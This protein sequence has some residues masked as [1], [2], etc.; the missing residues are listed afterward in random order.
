MYVEVREGRPGSTTLELLSKAR[1]LGT[2]DA[3]AL[4]PGAR[5]AAAALGSHGASRVLV[6]EDEAFAEYLAEPASDCL[7]GLVESGS[8]DL[9]LFSFTSDSRDVAGRLAARLGVGLISNAMDV[10]ASEAGF[11]ARVPYFGGAKVAT[12]R[13]GA[14]PAIVLVRPKS[15]EA[16]TTGGEA[17]VVEI[18]ARIRESSRRARIV[19]RRVEAAEQVK[20][21]DAQVVVSGGRGLG[22]PE[23]FHLVEELA[24]ALGGAAGA[25]RAIVDAGQLPAS[26]PY[27]GNITGLGTST[28]GNTFL[29]YT[30]DISGANPSV[31]QAIRD[32]N[33]GTAPFGPVPPERYEVY[34]ATRRVDLSDPRNRT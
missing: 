15:F 2:V 33:A 14:S 19:E 20:L 16:S 7:A 8:P 12:Y 29:G 11:R 31:P 30:A 10:E 17:E 13:A 9:I 23:N 6:N 22:G 32:L 27:Y 24:S 18:E 3:L 1:E 28:G 5:E 34:Q 26:G 21:E 25:S 4:G